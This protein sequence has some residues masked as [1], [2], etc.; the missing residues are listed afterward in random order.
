M[1]FFHQSPRED[2]HLRVLRDLDSSLACSEWILSADYGRLDLFELESSKALKLG[3]E[4]LEELLQ[5]ISG[6]VFSQ[7]GG[8]ISVF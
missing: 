8:S 5:E 1:I 4:R 6:I 7:G 2:R 3:R